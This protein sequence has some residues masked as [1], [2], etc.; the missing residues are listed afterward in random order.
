MNILI[1]NPR[2]HRAAWVRKNPSSLGEN[3]GLFSAEDLTRWACDLCMA[4]LD[5]EHPIH[6]LD[7]MSLCPACLAKCAP[8]GTDYQPFDRGGCQP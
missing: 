5:A 8:H 7:G 4:P 6:A 3:G 2:G 1:T